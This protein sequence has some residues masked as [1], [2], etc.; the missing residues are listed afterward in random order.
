MTALSPRKFAVFLSAA[1]RHGLL[2]V[3][4]E[5]AEREEEDIHPF[6]KSRAETLRLEN[7]AFWKDYSPLTG[8]RR[9]WPMH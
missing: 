4:A 9:R 6:S 3:M 5:T 8:A 7:R 2:P 1:L